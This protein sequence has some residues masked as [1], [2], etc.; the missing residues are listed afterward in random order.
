M[1]GDFD[2]DGNEDIMCL[3]S[4][5]MNIAWNSFEGLAPFRPLPF[6]N[7]ELRGG[8][9][10]AASRTLWLVASHPE[11]IETWTFQGT[12]P[13]PSKSF[14]LD[15]RSWHLTPG[16]GMTVVTSLPTA[17]H[18]LE[19]DGSQEILVP[20]A[21]EI[22]AAIYVPAQRGSG[23]LVLQEA[24]TGAVGC[25]VRAQGLWS[26]ATWWASTE[27]THS[28]QL[29]LDEDGISVTGATRMHLW[30]RAL[31]V[32][33]QSR[34]H[35]TKPGL[36]ECQFWLLENS[37]EK[38]LELVVRMTVTYDMIQIRLDR[39]TGNRVERRHMHEIDQVH[40]LVTPDL[41]GDGIQEVMHPLSGN[42][43]WAY[44]QP[45]GTVSRKV[46]WQDSSRG[47]ISWTP[48]IDAPQAWK[49]ALRDMGP[50]TE[51]WLH[52][53]MLLAQRDGTWWELTP[54]E[55]V[56]TAFREDASS[57]ADHSL[58]L[59][60]PYLEL[61][62]FPE[63]QANPTLAE[64][65]ANVW[66]HVVLMRN[67]R[68]DTEVWFN[69]ECVF[70]GKMA[71]LN[72]VHNAVIF[73]SGY[74]RTHK[75][76]AAASLDR[77]LV[78]GTWWTPEEIRGE[79]TQAR[80]MPLARVSEAWGFDE[81]TFSSLVTGAPS[82]TFSN[83]KLVD[84]V[85]GGALRLDGVDDVVR[86][87]ASLPMDESTVSFF[88][89]VDDASVTQPQTLLSLYGMFNIP[90]S[91]VKQARRNLLATDSAQGPYRS[92]RRI[93]ADASDL[94]DG[95]A[96]A[97]LQ[98]QL[99]A[100]APNGEVLQEGPLGWQ[101]VRGAST[102]G[103]HW[104]DQ[105]WVENDALHVL[106]NDGTHWQWT[107]ATAWECAAPLGLA[108]GTTTQSNASGTFFLHPDGWEWATST[109]APVLTPQD[110]VGMVVRTAW[111]PAGDFVEFED[112]GWEAWHSKKRSLAT[113]SSD[114][115]QQRQAVWWRSPA[116]LF[117]AALGSVIG[118]ALVTNHARRRAD[119]SDTPD[120][121]SLLAASRGSRAVQVPEEFRAMLL[122]VLAQGGAPMDTLALDL[123]LS[124][125]QHETD[126]TKRGRR[127]R[128]IRECNDWG[129]NALGLDVVVRSRD[130]QDRRRTLFQLHPEFVAWHR[131]RAAGEGTEEAR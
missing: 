33:G 82:E 5:Q 122:R 27:R 73:G 30:H 72:Y 21:S 12:S 43:D 63:G 99:H 42:G 103:P 24:S 118:V 89:R 120:N 113:T 59:H 16:A 71:D 81:P 29:A 119:A 22:Q 116:F 53:G 8:A 124:E 131:K 37:N 102:E 36:G 95:A 61:G 125:N 123:A 57:G 79:A 40:C 115:L 92:P 18:F 107:A 67:N 83:P 10:D 101:G 47:E 127:S 110:S 64:F 104:K 94:P 60:V 98:G 108:R 39:E 34:Y 17:I 69:G 13:R 4:K 51:V 117:L 23:L 112:H 54:E 6:P 80:P 2:G 111:T 11:R 25:S 109:E 32:K 66:N 7:G 114:S 52:R 106:A 68:L 62:T 87:F 50:V 90:I 41:D 129:R 93:R 58:Q 19:A 130:P 1:S 91:V 9:W 55:P 20:D 126:E 88:F 45:W 77:V 105:P 14:S 31:D 15:A 26:E 28:W 96:L 78:S 86:T 97:V 44:F 70:V 128:F 75:S 56:E 48:Q 84:G 76:F 46:F 121:D 65:E 35:W 38:E 85:D 74:G 49:E 3:E 100:L